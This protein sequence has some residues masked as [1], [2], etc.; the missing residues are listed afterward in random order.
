MVLFFHGM[1]FAVGLVMII[2]GSDW[3]IDSA[4]WTAEVFRIPP[5]IIG[6]TIISICT[7]LPETF[8]SITAAWRGETDMA[9]GNSLGSIGVNT[10]FIMALLLIFA[11]PVIDN[12]R[13][14][15][16]NGFFLIGVL[17]L[18]WLTGSFFGYIGRTA[19]FLLVII[20]L[21]FIV[22]N[23]MSVRKLMDLDIRY[24]IE[25]EDKVKSHYDP[26][27]DLPEGLAYDE[28]ENDFDVSRQ[29]IIR[30]VILFVIGISLVIVGSNF[31]VVNGI[32]IAEILRVPTILVAVIFTSVG[33]SLPEL[34]TTISSIRKGV[35]NL[36]VGNIIGANI[37]NIVQVVGI[38]ALISPISL[39]HDRSILLVQ[40][41]LVFLLI[42]LAVCFGIF[43]KKGFLRWQGILL[44]FLYFLF[45][46]INILREGT[47]I[48]GPYLF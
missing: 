30:K 18:V 39:S 15:K 43:S 29:E 35:T 16:E 22:K 48:I 7:T 14:F 38:T 25:D 9:I 34:I 24:D 27:K 5:I 42:T 11:T 17:L 36:G 8:V 31:L 33:T 19:G 37:L 41:P 47:P 45:L 46:I 6:V 44:L 23:V 13:E 32:K 3:F 4:V 20:M 40:L 28:V 10:G 1:L 26:S 12:R 21:L 2:K